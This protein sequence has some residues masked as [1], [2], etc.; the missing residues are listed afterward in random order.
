MTEHKNY[1]KFLKTLQHHVTLLKTQDGDVPTTRYVLM[2]YFHLYS[3]LI[4]VQVHYTSIINYLRLQNCLYL[5]YLPQSSLRI[6]KFGYPAL[7]IVIN[8]RPQSCALI[9]CITL[10]SL[11]FL[12]R[13]GHP[14]KITESSTSI[15][16]DYNNGHIEA[17]LLC[18]MYC[19]CATS[20]T[21]DYLQVSPS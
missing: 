2:N 21:Q 3:T 1:H 12:L 20:T 4:T 15:M 18:T 16:R 19:G 17:S 9:I 5:I 13:Y 8:S 11:Q 14:A 6:F 10:F 7:N